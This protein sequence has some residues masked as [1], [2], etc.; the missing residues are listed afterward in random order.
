MIS[1]G[2]MLEKM[3]TGDPFSCKVVKYDKAKGSSGKL[4]H[5]LEA[6]MLTNKTDENSMSTIARERSSTTYE[7][8]QEVIK[9]TPNH[10]RNYTRN[11]RFLINGNPSSTI[12][13]IHPLLVIEFNGQ[14]TMP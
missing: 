14:S 7:M 2:D 3:E 6:V 13:K 8:Q 1:I 9:K 10:R 5:V 12:V 11:I 4:M